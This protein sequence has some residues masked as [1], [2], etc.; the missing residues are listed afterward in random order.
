MRQPWRHPAARA[1]VLAVLL[2]PALPTASSTAATRLLSP[3]GSDSGPCTGAPCR[4]LG[5]AYRQAAP[6]DVVTLAGGSYGSHSITP[7]S[8]RGGPAVQFVGGPGVSLSSLDITAGNV[9]VRDMAIGSVDVQR[10][11]NVSIIGVTSETTYL[12][13]AT[14]LLLQGGSIGD[15]VDG[16]PLTIA[17]GNGVT[18]DRMDLHDATI[19]NPSAHSECIWISGTDG[20][21]VRNSLFR[22]CAY[23]DI[24]FTTYMGPNPTNVLVENS[25]FERTFTDGHSPAPYSIN[26]SDHLTRAENFTFR[27]NTFQT[28]IL[29][30]PS[31][32]ISNMT[33]A[34]NIGAGGC[35][36]GVT[37]IN[38]VWSNDKCSASDR[39]AAN[40]M[41]FF[42]DPARHDWHLQ[43]GS[44][45]IN[46]AD[47]GTA[48]ATDR[49]GYARIA[50]P[51]AGAHEYGA[52]PAT[53]PPAGSPAGS[54][55]STAGTSSLL[56]SAR[57]VPRRICA[58]A[59]GRCRFPTARLVV[60]AG[61][62]GRIE[63]RI[64]RVGANRQLRRVRL[65]RRTARAGRDVTLRIRA[66]TLRRGL[67]V[68]SVVV[69]DG[70]GRRSSV[71]RVALRVR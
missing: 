38:N 25:V 71:E 31:G 18:L 35:R 59:T 24:F 26:I 45:A 69:V 27:N 22:N 16:A 54:L 36:A 15:H 3:S 2:V 61:A 28:E 42:V 64:Y 63:A 58:R 33:F 39:R 66:R 19:Q 49:D 52:G 32:P 46:A 60:R 8:G 4:T 29:I 53:R 67:Y 56:R 30:Q 44:P 37:F 70:A 12:G 7:V 57:L 47:P 13:D 5:Y 40:V 1:V 43:A 65:L 51:D 34:N 55:G 11:A 20:F 17:G 21:T 68:I 6:G 48:T 9:V 10:A 41:S 50:P 14:N 23:F 62:A